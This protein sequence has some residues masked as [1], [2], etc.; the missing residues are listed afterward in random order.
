[1]TPDYHKDLVERNMTMKATRSQLTESTSE[2]ED[3]VSLHILIL[4]SIDGHL[5]ADCLMSMIIKLR[6]FGLIDL[7]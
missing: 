1:M 4:I 5:R 6:G 3:P 7:S 2:K